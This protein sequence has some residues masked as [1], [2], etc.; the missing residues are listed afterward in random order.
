MLP[1]VLIPSP[2]GEASL[3]IPVPLEQALVGQ[4]ASVQAVI[5]H[6]LQASSWRVSNVSRAT[7][8]R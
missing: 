2:S 3:T 1:P 7:I 6:D 8:Q 5:A 4:T